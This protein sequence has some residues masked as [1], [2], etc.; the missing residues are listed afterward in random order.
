M[1]STWLS[2]DDAVRLFHALLVE[3]DLRFEVVYGI[4]ANTRAWWDLGPAR[5]LGYEPKDDSELFAAEILAA[6]GPLDPDDPDARYLG[7]RFTTHVPPPTP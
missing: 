6:Q 1:L 4:S 3:P 2:P 7:G 5:R